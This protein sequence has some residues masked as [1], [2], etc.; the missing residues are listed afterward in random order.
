MKSLQETRTRFRS[1]DFRSQLFTINSLC[2]V[3]DSVSSAG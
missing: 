1:S 2:S 3:A